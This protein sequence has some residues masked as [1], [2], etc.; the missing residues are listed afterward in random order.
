M[1][2][3]KSTPEQIRQ[4]FDQDVERF[5][6]LETGQSATVDAPLGLELIAS[7]AAAVNPD[8]TALLDIGCGAGNYSLKL[9]QSLPLR[10]ISLIEAAADL[11]RKSTRLNSSH[12]SES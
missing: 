8:A 10:S 7:A 2:P 4:R 6:N 5:A 9:M 1:A 11:D 12:V 3:L